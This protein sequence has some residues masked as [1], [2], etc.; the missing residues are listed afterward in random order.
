M[1]GEKRTQRSWVLAAVRVSDTKQPLSP[2][3]FW[4]RISITT[5]ELKYLRQSHWTKLPFRRLLGSPGG[6]VVLLAKEWK[7]LCLMLWCRVRFWKGMSRCT[8][9]CLIS[10]FSYFRTS[11]STSPAL[12]FLWCL[13]CSQGF[14]Q[15]Y[16]LHSW[17]GLGIC[18]TGFGSEQHKA[19]LQV[20]SCD[21]ILF[22]DTSHV[23]LSPIPLLSLFL[24]RCL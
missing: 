7:W 16:H 6:L 12:K 14:V 10:C 13:K 5:K 23:S 11:D 22:P 19:Y 8:F 18:R 1:A 24:L 15:P 3:A 9:G 2:W 21:G 4:S 20:I 17:A